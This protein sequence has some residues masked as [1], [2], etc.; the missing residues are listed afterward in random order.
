M[1]KG[2]ATGEFELIGAIVETLGAASTGSHVLI[3]PGDDAAMI[4]LPAGEAL[5]T[6]VDTL[7]PDVHFPAAAAAQLIGQRS[8]RVS[9]S[10]LAAM[11]AKPLACVISLVL[12]K[13]TNP[14]WVRDLS[15]GFADAALAFDCPVTG[16][17]LT[18]GPLSICVTVQ[19]CVPAALALTRGGAQ[20]GDD[21]WVSGALGGAAVALVEGGL[22][23]VPGLSAGAAMTQAQHQYFLPL[24]QLILGVALREVATSAIDISDGLAAD[25]GHIVQLS[26]VTVAL[27]GAAIPRLAGASLEQALYGG[28][29]YQLCFTAPP[30]QRTS[31]G[32][33]SEG[34]C[35]IGRVSS[36]APE[37][38][39]DGAVLPRRGFDH[40]ANKDDQ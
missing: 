26:E 12:P 40:F 35:R 27:D 16:G 1:T 25:L 33:L 15:R 32:Q 10:D 34:V 29:D 19:G 13:S 9:V 3:G 21:V 23:S 5:V 36:G 4:A 37:L 17:N 22:D 11:G 30:S 20:P 28:D 18:A 38:L 2:A 6:S 39:L 14:Q 8:L 24:P 31:V 7:L